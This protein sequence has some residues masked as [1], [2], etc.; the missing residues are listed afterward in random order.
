MNGESL[1]LLSG[2]QYKS[3]HAPSNFALNESLCRSQVYKLVQD[4]HRIG[5]I[6]GDLEPRNIAR[7]RGGGGEFFLI[8]F[9]ESKKRHKCKESKVCNMLLH[10]PH[11]FTLQVSVCLQCKIRSV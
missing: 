10:E 2:K 6:H 4:L 9:S 1:A 5:I 7:A 11:T 3:N 8:D